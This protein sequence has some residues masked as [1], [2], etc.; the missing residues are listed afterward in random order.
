MA[1]TTT[2]LEVLDQIVDVLGGQSGQYETVVPTLQQIRDLLGGGGG[3]GS[4]NPALSVGRADALTGADST[5]RWATRESTGSG[6]ATVRSVQGATV[7][8]NQLCDATTRSATYRGIDYA[9]ADGKITLS[10]TSTGVASFTINQ[11]IKFGITAGHK[12][13]VRGGDRA[14]GVYIIISNSAFSGAMYPDTIYTA[15]GS[16]TQ[17]SMSVFVDNGVTVSHEGYPALFDLT[18]MFGSGNEPTTVAEFEAMYSEAY[19]P[20]S[21]PTLKPVQIAGIASTDANGDALDSVEWEAY[22]LRAA[23]SVADMLYSDHVDVRVGSETIG[24][25]DVTLVEVIENPNSH[26]I[27]S[28]TYQ[29]PAR[30]EF[31][32][33]RSYNNYVTIG[34]CN[35]D[36]SDQKS[37]TDTTKPGIAVSKQNKRLYVRKTSPFTDASVMAELSAN[38]IQM[39][40]ALLT[41]TTTP[42]SP[43]LPMTYRVKQGG[44]ES[45][46]VPTGEI[47]AV[48]VL[49]IA[50]GESAADVVMDALA[51]IAAPDGPVATANHAVNT[52][53]TMG[54]K[55][56]KVT[57]A[58]A[59]G[60]TIAA[61][62][63]VTETTVMD[64]LIALTA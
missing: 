5:A 26:G 50:E 2:E 45:I 38:P 23:G 3:G 62:T 10:G 47:S 30:Y 49:T 40:T 55:L 19:Y 27:Y 1:D 43:A 48:P 41:P 9:C 17:A 60:E 33:Y 46:I 54:G 6:M 57:T 8:W 25:D 42:I 36:V 21:A 61:G 15:T 28:A 39:Y 18:A 24:A 20:Y 64:E 56:Y 13:I 29:L 11:N 32:L 14:K 4:Y 35:Y 12:Y 31:S 63:N 58:I 22:T 53:L 44:T 52:Y 34:E 16:L 51:C 37:F 59:A 7:G